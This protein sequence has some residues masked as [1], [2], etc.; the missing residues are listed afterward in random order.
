[1]LNRLSLK[2]L[3]LKLLLQEEDVFDMKW[4]HWQN[5]FFIKVCFAGLEFENSQISIQFYSFQTISFGRLFN[6]NAF[7]LLFYFHSTHVCV[8]I[9]LVIEQTVNLY[10]HLQYC[11]LVRGNRRFR[12]RLTIVKLGFLE[13]HVHE[14][15][16]ILYDS[17]A[18]LKS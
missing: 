4:Q 18:G 1:M 7:E 11:R 10:Y 12:Q 14:T 17:D 5:A 9:Q 15:V 8:W 2:S 13:F 6:N 3:I 16:K